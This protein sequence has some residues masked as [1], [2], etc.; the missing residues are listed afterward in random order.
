MHLE[1]PPNIRF[2]FNYHDYKCVAAGPEYHTERKKNRKKFW[3]LCMKCQQNRIAHAAEFSFFFR[4][5]NHLNIL[6][7]K[8]KL[9]KHPARC[10]LLQKTSLLQMENANY[11]YYPGRWSISDRHIPI[12]Y[13]VQYKLNHGVKKIVRYTLFVWWRSLLMLLSL[14]LFM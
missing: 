6:T 9:S 10:T 14:F 8:R 12:N 2:A 7:S 3:P 4:R 11:Q 1:N 13:S 5:E